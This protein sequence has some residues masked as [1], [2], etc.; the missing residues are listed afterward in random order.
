[1]QH[2]VYSNRGTHLTNKARHNSS[3]LVKAYKARHVLPKRIRTSASNDSKMWLSSSS[4][5]LANSPHLDLIFSDAVYALPAGLIRRGCEGTAIA[6]T[7]TSSSSLSTS[8]ATEV[9]T[10]FEGRDS[11]VAMPG[12]SRMPGA[13]S[14]M[15]RARCLVFAQRRRFRGCKWSRRQT[16]GQ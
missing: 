9:L 11:T 6:A 13:M 8:V 10:L 4:G 5:K 7:A 3:N 14:K 1:M 12:W 2:V 16:K 15:D